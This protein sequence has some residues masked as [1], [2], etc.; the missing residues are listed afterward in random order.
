MLRII[1]S[2]VSSETTGWSADIYCKIINNQK[3]GQSSYL[4]QNGKKG[5]EAS[6]RRE[7]ERER[8]RVCE[9]VVEN[10]GSV[11][12]KKGHWRNRP[13]WD[14]LGSRWKDYL[15]SRNYFNGEG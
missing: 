1:V 2:R 7:R 10:G 12:C 8:E 5:K 3:H 4:Y 14:N 15:I 6:Y 11:G 13:F 9:R